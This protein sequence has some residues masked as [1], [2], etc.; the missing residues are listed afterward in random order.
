METYPGVSILLVMKNERRNMEMILPILQS[1]R[2][3]GAVDYVYIDSGSTDGTIE[4]MRAHGIEA[5]PI[6]PHE[7]HHGRTR[8]LAASLATQDVLVLLSGDAFPTSDTWLSNL[9]APFSDERVGAVYGRQI[10]PDHLSPLRRQALASEYPLVRQV[11]DLAVAEKVHPGL[12]R[13]SNVNAAVRR[14]LWA[15][16]RWNESLLLAEDQGMCRDILMAGYKVV[17]EPEAAVMHGHDR[18]LLGEFKFA[19]DNGISLTRL[20]ILNNPEIPGEFRY[21]ISR[22]RADLGHFLGEQEYGHAIRTMMVAVVKW[23]GVQ[24]GKRE[25]L[26]PRWL[27]RRISEVHQKVGASV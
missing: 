24:L 15:R 13:F 18:T 2:Y 16:F 7:F 19:T 26:I 27:L 23:C 12:F 22:L 25:R 1:Q 14:D 11:R 21:G 4:L 20:G 17:Y 6:A 10:A 8:N 3:N 9:V 5:H